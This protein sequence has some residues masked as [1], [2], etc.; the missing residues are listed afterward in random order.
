MEGDGLP[1]DL[2]ICLESR[3]PVPAQGAHIHPR[4]VPVGHAAY[5]ALLTPVFDSILRHLKAKR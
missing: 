1:E 5:L 3:E 2:P 4:P